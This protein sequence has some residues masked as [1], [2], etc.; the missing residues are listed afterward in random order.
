MVQFL[1]MPQ[2]QPSPLLDLSPLAQGL[3]MRQ[4]AQQMQ[5]AQQAAAQKFAE[6]QRQFNATNSLQARQQARADEKS[7][8]EM[9]LLQAQAAQARARAGAYSATP[10]LPAAA[11]KPEPTFGMREDGSIYEEGAGETSLAGG[12]GGPRVERRVLGAGETVPLESSRENLDFGQ[13]GM[14]PRAVP[15]V[16]VTDKGN[17]DQFA[18][19]EAQGQRAI[20]KTVPLS[21]RDRFNKFQETQRT[22]TATLGKPRPGYMY[23]AQG[24][25]V[26]K[27]PMSSSAEQSERTGRA[28]SMIQEDINDSEKTLTSGWFPGIKRA[29]APTLNNLGAPGKFANNMLG[30]ENEAEAF[31]KVK[32]GVLQGV[33]ALSGKQT[34]NKEM[35]A[36]LDNFMPKGGESADMLKSKMGRLRRLLSTL[37]SKVKKGMVYDDAEREALTEIG[38]GTDTQKGPP[39]STDRGAMR[40]KNK[41]GL[42]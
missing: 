22:W 38:S 16:V 2:Y 14:R 11:P 5:A 6:E 28:I 34:T 32:M 18:T 41:Y 24:R 25:E 12:D 1:N 19:K 8:Y 3:Q 20:D 21:D 15:G 9:D 31:N 29:V 4:K 37:Q 7:P 30:L 13:Y 10:S 35:D 39:A 23:D 26:P 40:I 36:F 27:G 17:S 33:Y 42:E